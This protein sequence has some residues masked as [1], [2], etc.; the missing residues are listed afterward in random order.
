MS[1][2]A[3][4]WLVL[5]SLMVTFAARASFAQDGSSSDGALFLLLPVGAQTVGMGQATVAERLGSESIWSNPA[6]IA[7]DEKRELAIHHSETIAAR[8]D[9]ITQ[10]VPRRHLG[11]VDVRSEE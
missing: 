4:R 5:T 1:K 3:W 11:A 7:R 2:Q 8:G 9:V 10:V 6:A